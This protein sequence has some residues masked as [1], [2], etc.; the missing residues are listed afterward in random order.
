MRN[1][2][3]GVYNNDMSTYLI[4]VNQLTTQSSTMNQLASFTVSVNTNANLLMF[5][6]DFRKKAIAAY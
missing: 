4:S 1:T 5:E 3:C 6:E 2:A